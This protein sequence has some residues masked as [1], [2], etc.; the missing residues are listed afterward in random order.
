MLPVVLAMGT[1]E[2]RQLGFFRGAAE[3]IVRLQG[4]VARRANGA[5]PL[6]P[7]SDW[8]TPVDIEDVVVMPGLLTLDVRGGDGGLPSAEGEGEEGEEGEEGV[9]AWAIAGEWLSTL[10]EAE[11]GGEAVAAAPGMKPASMKRA[12]MQRRRPSSHALASHASA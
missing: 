3:R 11:D 2:A 1:V 12:F 6:E 8:A 4:E 7:P 9:A 5:M 10:E